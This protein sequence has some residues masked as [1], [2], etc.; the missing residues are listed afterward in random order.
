MPAILLELAVAEAESLTRRFVSSQ[1]I[2][3][4]YQKLDDS[5]Q[6]NR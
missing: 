1:K 5:L 2:S 4:E 6:N 3:E